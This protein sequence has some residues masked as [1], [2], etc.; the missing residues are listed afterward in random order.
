MC[1]AS[2]VDPRVIDRYL[3]GVTIAATLDDLPA[4]GPD[5]SK[6]RTRERI[7]SA[8]LDLLGEHRPTARRAAQ[9]R[10]DAAI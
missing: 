1:R 10:L 8:V 4:A 9:P 3:A 7:E 6:P 2:Y 5:L